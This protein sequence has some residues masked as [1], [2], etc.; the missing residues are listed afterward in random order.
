MP[1]SRAP[2]GLFGEAR[3]LVDK[4][5]RLILQFM[6]IRVLLNRPVRAGL[7]RRWHDG[8][9]QALLLRGR[10]S[11]RNDFE[12]SRNNV[13][14]SFGGTHSRSTAWVESVPIA[15]GSA[16]RRIG[17][18]ECV[19]RLLI[20]PIKGL[21]RLRQGRAQRHPGFLSRLLQSCFGVRRMRLHLLDGCIDVGAL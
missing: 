12:F 15:V 18:L 4:L 6:L 5:T 7:Y 14:G 17:A 10:S 9:H 21:A 16:L 3:D 13:V 20:G 2:P 19:A 8:R 1:R 11:S